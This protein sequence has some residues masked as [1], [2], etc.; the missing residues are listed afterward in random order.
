MAER[1]VMPCG[2]CPWRVGSDPRSIPG[3]SAAKAERLAVGCQGDGH[4][5]MACH[6]STAANPIPCAGFVLVLGL[7]SVGVRIALARGWF[8][9]DDFA[10]GGARLY[11]S[12]ATMLG[13]QRRKLR[14]RARAAKQG[15]R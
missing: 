7:E 12:F 10:R 8:R 5:A 3:Y 1:K 14:R 11:R 13:N 15:A 4:N 6:K 2:N 9:L